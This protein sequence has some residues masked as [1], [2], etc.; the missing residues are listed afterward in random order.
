MFYTALKGDTH[1]K[2]NC[3]SIRKSVLKTSL[4]IRM[5]CPGRFTSLYSKRDRS[6]MLLANSR[7][8]P[9]TTSGQITKPP[10]ASVFFLAFLPLKKR[11]T[12]TF[13]LLSLRVTIKIKI[14]VRKKNI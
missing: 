11:N 8:L 6:V 2:A 7:M 5:G 3:S 9:L 1:R 14:Y 13:S 10:Q 12:V 4:Q